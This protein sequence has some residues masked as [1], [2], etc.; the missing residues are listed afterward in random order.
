MTFRLSGGRELRFSDV[1]RFG[2]VWLLEKDE[3]DSYSGVEKLG[4]E[5]FSDLTADYLAD[6][7]GKRRKA[8]K[9][10]LLEQS[11]IAGHRQHLCRRDSVRRANQ[12]VA[13]RLQSDRRRV[14]ASRRR[15]PGAAFL[16]HRKERGHARGVLECERA[17]I[18]QHAVSAGLRQGGGALP[19]CG[20]PLRRQG[21]RRQ[22][23]HLLSALP[24]G[25]KGGLTALYE[26]RQMWY[27]RRVKCCA[28]QVVYMAA[29]PALV[30]RLSEFSA[31]A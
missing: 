4:P 14:G 27:N 7:F 9:E 10:C 22:R 31:A 24:A 13:R 5:P 23:Q 8:V 15:Y 29:R 21:D 18:P 2:R 6:R 17:G 19:V 30:W 28:A 3:A 20:E 11:V 12:S 25:G 1:R 26:R 16:F